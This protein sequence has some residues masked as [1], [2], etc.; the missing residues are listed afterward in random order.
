[1]RTFGKTGEKLVMNYP[2]PIYSRD[3]YANGDESYIN[4]RLKVD[5]VQNIVNYRTV[6]I[7]K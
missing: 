5:K 4:G 2:P 1:M 3:G 6:F 7:L